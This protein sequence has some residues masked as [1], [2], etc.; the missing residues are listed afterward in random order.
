MPPY[1]LQSHPPMTLFQLKDVIDVN[2]PAGKGGDTFRAIKAMGSFQIIVSMISFA[3]YMLTRAPFV[4]RTAWRKHA[5][6]NRYAF[7]VNIV[8]SSIIVHLLYLNGHIIEVSNLLAHV[9]L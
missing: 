3:M 6:E 4:I 5:T 2:H 9:L 7:F 8:F 1:V